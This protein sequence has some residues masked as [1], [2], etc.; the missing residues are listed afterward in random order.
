VTKSRSGEVLRL[1]GSTGTRQARWRSRS[2]DRA[3]QDLRKRAESRSDKFLE[4]AL[5]LLSEGGA[6]N[7][8]V[9]KV[10][11]M[12]GMSLRS[13]YQLFASRDDLFLAIY[14]EAILGAVERQMAA[15]DTVGDDPLSRLRA[16]LEAEWIANEESPPV[17][18]RSLVI[19]HQRLMESR[20]AELA[21]VLE[22][23]Q[24]A[25]AELVSECRGA[26]IVVSPLG[27]SAIASILMQL[28]MATL[29]ARALDFQLDGQGMDFDQ[30]WAVAAASFLPAR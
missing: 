5:E 18:R 25:L 19:Y 24:K 1:P 26:G 30:V 4:I 10:V 7:L 17:L 6:D 9:R 23:Q 20:P 21:A 8:S 2:A 22:P 11:D 13:F 12:S 15:V 28:M 29:Q 3:T 27:D 16:F 14:E